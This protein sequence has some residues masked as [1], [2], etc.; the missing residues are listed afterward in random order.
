MFKEDGFP[1]SPFPNG[2]KGKA[3]LYAVGFTRKGLSGASFDAIRVAQDIGQ[4]WKQELKQKNK[5]QKKKN[6]NQN[7]NQAVVSVTCHRRSK[8]HC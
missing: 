1:K 2:W 7:Q 6:Q 3:G 4:I 5:N 8:S